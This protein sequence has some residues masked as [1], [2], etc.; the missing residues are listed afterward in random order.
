M[1]YPSIMYYPT[2]IRDTPFTA[3]EGIPLHDYL[4]FIG[5]SPQGHASVLQHHRQLR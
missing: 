3:A 2:A 5:A 4:L 1:R